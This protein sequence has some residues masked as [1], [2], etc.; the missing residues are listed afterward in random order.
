MGLQARSLPKQQ[1][2]SKPNQVHLARQL[3]SRLF[4]R[5]RPA[6]DE[7]FRPLEIT[8]AVVSLLQRSEQRIVVQPVGMVVAKA[9]EV[10]AQVRSRAGSEVLPGRLEQRVLEALDGVQVDGRG[11]TRATRA[12]GRSHQSVLDQ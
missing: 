9:F 1:E 11:R 2:L 7:V 10:G 4:E 12:V 3:A 8:G 5:G 6:A